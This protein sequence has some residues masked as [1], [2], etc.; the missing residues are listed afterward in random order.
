[1]EGTKK[2]AGYSR[3][4]IRNVSRGNP[5]FDFTIVGAGPA[6]ST[7]A[8]LLARE[9]Y[10]VVVI[11]KLSGSGVC[12]GEVLAPQWSEIGRVL[13]LSDVFA[14]QNHRVSPGVVS[15]WGSAEPRSNDYIFNPH[16]MGW[17]LDRS[18]FNSMLIDAARSAGSEAVREGVVTSFAEDDQGWLLTVAHCGEFLQ[19]RSRFLIDAG[20]RASRWSALHSER[21]VYDRLVAVAI[22][23]RRPMDF[24][25]TDCALVEAVDQGWFYSVATPGDEAVIVYMTDADLYAKGRRRSKDFFRE[26]L[27]KALWTEKRMGEMVSDPAIHSAVSSVRERVAGRNWLVA[28]DAGRSF[29]PLSS[30]GIMSAIRSG[31]DAAKTVLQPAKNN[32]AHIEEYEARNRRAF[33]EYLVTHRK[34]YG[35]EMRWPNSEFWA[36]RQGRFLTPLSALTKRESPK[37]A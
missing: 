5:F 33:A 20:G 2:S 13:G 17:H 16:G 19:V 9:G 36:R 8:L 21:F 35:M 24:P 3:R 1:M 6:G 34:V 30:Q 31:I 28:G 15:A 22:H 18:G 32:S 29:D 23:Y 10:S 37:S 11:D 25:W 14:K 7:T 27:Q 4:G 26:Q 12:M